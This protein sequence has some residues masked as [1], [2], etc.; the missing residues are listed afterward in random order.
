MTGI[1]EVAKQR[2]EQYGVKHVL[3]ATAGGGSINPRH[4]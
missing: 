3:V 4:P 1:F 2:A